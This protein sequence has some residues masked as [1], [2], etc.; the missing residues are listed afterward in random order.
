MSI[1]INSFGIFK[2]N[3]DEISIKYKFK[4]NKSN[5]LRIFGDEFV[6]NNKKIV[7]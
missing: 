4:N 3:I 1:V 2:N 5:I 6:E 7:D